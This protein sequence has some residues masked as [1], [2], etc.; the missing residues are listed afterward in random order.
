MIRTRGLEWM[1]AIVGATASAEAQDRLDPTAADYAAATA[2]LEGNL[3]GTVKNQSIEPH[4]IGG[5]GSFWYRRDEPSG[6]SYVRFDGRSKTKGPLFDHE[7]LAAAISA[8]AG[9]ALGAT[10]TD[11]KLTAVAIGP[12]ARTLQGTAGARRLTC[13]LV[14]GT[15]TVAEGKPPEPG[16]LP[17]PDGKRALLVRGGNLVIRDLGTGAETPL[18]ADAEPG[19]GYATLYGT[20]QVAKFARTGVTLPPLGAAWSP[21]GRYLIAPRNDERAAAVTPFVEWAPMDGSRRP[22][23]YQVRTAFPGDQEGV[24]SSHHLF[25]VATGRRVAIAAPARYADG[26]HNVPIGW[27]ASRNQVFLLATGQGAR[28]MALLRVDL[29]TGAATA[30]IEESSTTRLEA[31]TYQNNGPNIQ[32]LADGREALWYSARSGWGHLY[33][34]D[35]QTGALLNPVTTGDWPVF[36]LLLVDEHRGTVY[37]TAGG[38]EPGHDPYYRQLYAVPLAGGA[39]R[40]LTDPAFDHDFDP[41]RALILRAM[42]GRDPAQQILPDA[43]VFLDTYSTVSTPPITVLRSLSDGKA[44]AEIERAD[45][46]AL[47]AAGWKPPIRE[48][49]KAADGKTDLYVTYDAPTRGIGREKHPIIDAAYGGPQTTVAPR[50]FVDAY[51]AANPIVGRRA[52][53]RLGFGVVTIDGRGTPFRSRAFRDAEDPRFTQVG[54]DDHIAALRQLAERHPELDLARVGVYGW[55]WGGTFAAQA[56]LSKPEFYSVAVATAGVYDYSSLYDGFQRYLGVPRYADGSAIRSRAG[57]IPTNWK[58]LD[59]TTLAGNLTGRLMLAYGDLDE[60]VPPQQVTRLVDALTRANKRYDL[61][62]LPNRNH[63]VA[64][65][66]YTIKRTWD[67]FVEHLL[68]AEPVPDVKVVMKPPYALP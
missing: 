65:E 57:E 62:Y 44:L 66:G 34:Y 36:D 56:I 26:I 2:L 6:V 50:N 25:E 43:G 52:L 33:R 54:I 60:N 64:L 49:V 7:R 40:L 8:A 38:R 35:A 67:Y 55:S 32:L 48:T 14:A 23:G 10:A 16:L 68:R 41:P 11:L 13:D 45:A 42:R 18:T 31:N 15:C 47:Y 3:R 58:D 53:A 9:P 37:F 22:I 46:T 51:S 5:D 29:A 63:N 19:V 20:F 24:H 4:W 1:M 61:V 21:D 39:P 27:S 12:D 59:I 28:S 30:V 17:S